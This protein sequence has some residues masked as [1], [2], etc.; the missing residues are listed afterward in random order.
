[1]KGLI[2]F[3]YYYYYYY[4]HTVYVTSAGYLFLNVHKQLKTHRFHWIKRVLLSLASLYWTD[5]LEL[6]SGLKTSF[7]I[8]VISFSQSSPFICSYISC[9]LMFVIVY[10]EK[11][12]FD[13]DENIK[14]HWL[15]CQP[16]AWTQNLRCISSHSFDVHTFQNSYRLS[17]ILCHWICRRGTVYPLRNEECTNY[18]TFNSR[19]DWLQTVF[20]RVKNVFSWPMTMHVQNSNFDLTSVFSSQAD[21]NYSAYCSCSAIFF[22][23][24]IT[25]LNELWRR[26]SFKLISWNW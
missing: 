16:H 10:C 9:N 22:I 4:L 23:L 25:L 26:V 21:M 3:L 15:L 7:I 14:V 20:K 1:M 11:E 6:W 24:C 18:P 13:E 5:T 2:S 19:K 8:H 12:S 17:S